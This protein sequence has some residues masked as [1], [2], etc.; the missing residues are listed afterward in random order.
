[1]HRRACKP[2]RLLIGRQ[3]KCSDGEGRPVIGEEKMYA[4]PGE[5]CSA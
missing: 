3:G 1:M 2:A 5:R 4:F